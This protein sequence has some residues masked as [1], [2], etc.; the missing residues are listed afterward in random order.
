[1]SRRYCYLVGSL[2]VVV[3]FASAVCSL[4][5]VSSDAWFVVEHTN[6][7]KLVVGLVR[8]CRGSD[9]KQTA[10]SALSHCGN[11]ADAIEL[12]FQ[13]IAGFFV[14]FT[15]AM[16]AVSTQSLIAV[17]FVKRVTPSNDF[18]DPSHWRTAFV[19]HDELVTRRVFGTPL[20][21]GAGLLLGVVG[22]ILWSSTFSSFVE[23]G[24]DMCSFYPP[25][26]GFTCYQGF[27]RSIAIAACVLAALQWVL[28][29]AWAA[30]FWRMQR[31]SCFSDAAVR[32]TPKAAAPEKARPPPPRKASPFLGPAPP[33]VVRERPLV[34]EPTP[35]ADASGRAISSQGLDDW[36]VVEG[37]AE[38]DVLLYSSAR[39]LYYHVASHRYYDPQT[40]L[41]Y[42]DET[43]TWEELADE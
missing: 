32:A 3:A 21:S 38:S 5:A 15:M 30:F 33:P 19:Y 28:S 8:T 43:F 31:D 41:W 26:A 4:L 13:A 9:C 42:N 2:S 22:H 23:C 36:S 34:L 16:I 37:E 27:G 7:T 25:S 11:G 18:P 20:V 17:G 39:N 12:R 35:R 6:Q 29:A 1:M 14:V 10:Y 40:T 24:S